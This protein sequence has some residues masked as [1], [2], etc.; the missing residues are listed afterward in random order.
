MIQSAAFLARTGSVFCSL[1]AHA[2]SGS[3]IALISH[4]DEQFNVRAANID[5]KSFSL[6]AR[7]A[8]QA[9]GVSDGGRSTG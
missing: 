5:D 6:H 2:I 4:R 9:L 8:T 7:T 1:K 3:K